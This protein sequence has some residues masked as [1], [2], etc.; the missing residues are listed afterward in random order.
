MTVKNKIKDTTKPHHANLGSVNNL[1]QF[2]GFI[3]EE[4]PKLFISTLVIIGVVVALLSI[5]ITVGKDWF[6]LES[7]VD[8]QTLTQEALKRLPNFSTNK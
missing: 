3:A 8:K 5:K 7:K 2:L 1:W 4:R 6:K